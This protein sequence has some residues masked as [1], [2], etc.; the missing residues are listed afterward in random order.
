VVDRDR[1][2][3]MAHEA[4]TERSRRVA[5]DLQRLEDPRRDLR[6][7]GEPVVGLQLRGIDEN[8]H[9]D[10]LLSLEAEL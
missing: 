8:G 10:S 6:P 2:D 4:R 3:A 5:A 1:A 7:G 9:A